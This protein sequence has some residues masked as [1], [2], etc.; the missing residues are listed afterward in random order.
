MK[1][2]KLKEIQP[3][4]IAYGYPKN[5]NQMTFLGYGEEIIVEGCNEVLSKLLPLCN[6]V[7]R[8]ENIL[9]KLED[10]YEKDSL[11]EVIKILLENEV[12][13]D[14][15]DFYWVFHKHSMNPPLCFRNLS[16]NEII[17]ILRRRNYK[18]YKARD[19]ISLSSSQEIDS[20]LLEF[21]K[22][23]QSIWKYSLKEMSFVKLSGL[24]R[25]A[26]GVI[27]RENLGS[28]TIPHRTVPSGGA[29]YPLEI[30][31]VTL[32]G[33][34]RLEKGLYYFQK[35]KECMI[36]LKKGNFR[37]KLKKLLLEVN[38][39]IETASLFLIVTAYFSRECEKYSNRGYRHILLEAGHLAQNVYLYCIDQNLG[40]LEISGFLDEELCNFLGINAHDES[41]ITI[42]AV[43]SR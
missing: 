5:A 24:L 37:D 1:K 13:I 22:S 17:D 31:V 18:S 35:E 34:G 28:Y 33:I 3:L 15:R 21:M 7:D 25:A 14:S 40:T 23:R 26:Y 27:R 10:E 43:G 6:G 20:A 30:Y 32:A 11:I 8:F 2:D 9:N 41:P 12:L 42:L 36:S 16:E 39:T 4:V 19:Q 38:E 29:L